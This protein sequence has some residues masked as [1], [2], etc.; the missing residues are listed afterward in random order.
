[1][2]L[3]HIEIVV[4][5]ERDVERLVEHAVPLGVI[6]GSILAAHA[7]HGKLAWKQLF[8]PATRLARDGWA[9]TPRFN[10]FVARMPATGFFNDWAKAYLYTADGTAKPVGTVVK[11]P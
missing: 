6:P 9:I 5:V 7:E 1:M 10:N 4:L 2:A 8:G 3:H 11:N